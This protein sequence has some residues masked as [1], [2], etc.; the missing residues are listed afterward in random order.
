MFFQWADLSCTRRLDR[1]TGV[2]V[3]CSVRLSQIGIKYYTT[4]VDVIQLISVVFCTF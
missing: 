3:L 4:T 1:M 2:F